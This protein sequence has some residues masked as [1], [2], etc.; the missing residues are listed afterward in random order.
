[1]LYISHDIVFPLMWWLTKILHPS[2]PAPTLQMLPTHCGPPVKTFARIWSKTT[3]VKALCCDLPTSRS[4]FHSEHG[5]HATSEA[6]SIGT[7]V[8]LLEGI[9]LTVHVP[10]GFSLEGGCWH[11]TVVCPLINH[12][13]AVGFMWP[14]M[15]W[16]WLFLRYAK[17][18]CAASGNHSWTQQLRPKSLVMANCQKKTKTG[19]YE[20]LQSI[21]HVYNIVVVQRTEV[22]QG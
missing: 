7:N 8:S 15:W 2:V 3:P 4:V 21:E 10:S 5:T 16:N 14:L 19:F 22:N 1:M 17:L 9:V 11:V 6:F 18:Y 13:K 12:L 20:L